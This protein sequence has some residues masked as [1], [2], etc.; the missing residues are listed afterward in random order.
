MTRDDDF[1]VRPGRIR[2]SRARSAPCLCRSRRSPP[3]RGPAAASSRSGKHHRGPAGHFPARPRR[4][5]SAPIAS[6]T[7]RTRFCTVKAR[8]WSATESARS[9]R[10]SSQLSPPLMASPVT[11]S[12]RRQF[13][14]G[15]RRRQRQG[16]PP[17]AAGRP[18]PLPLHRSARRRGDMEDLEAVHPRTDG[19]GR[20]LGTKLEWLR[21]ITGTPTTPRPAFIVPR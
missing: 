13:R 14:P 4:E 17:S 11:A 2:S 16:V 21:S 15:D 6:S 9:A 5:A 12:A 3:R 8:S 20:D 7:S 1:H 19:A 10:P 18:A